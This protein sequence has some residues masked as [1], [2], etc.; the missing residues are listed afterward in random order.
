MWLFCPALALLSAVGYLT[1]QT[2]VGVDLD[3]DD[4][5]LK[6]AGLRIS[7][8]KAS[9]ELLEVNYDELLTKS[10]S[11]RA[12]RALVEQARTYGHQANYR[13]SYDRLWK[14][15]TLADKIGAPIAKADVYV[16]LGRYYSFYKRMDMAVSYFDKALRIGKQ[17]VAIRNA[18]ASV[19]AKY[20]YAFA[21]TYREMDEPAH[22]RRYLDSSVMYT[23]AGGGRDYTHYQK[24]EAG[25]C[26]AQEGK[27][28]EA[29][30]AYRSALPW[31]SDN[32]PGYQTLVYFYL[33]NVYT[34][35]GDT[36]RGQA[37][38]RKALEIS[39]ATSSHL[40]FTPLIYNKLALLYER[41]G[42]YEEAYEMSRRRNELNYRFFDSR[43]RY[44]RP[45]LEIQDD[46]REEQ[47]AREQSEQRERLMRLEEGKRLDRLKLGA[48]LVSLF[49]TLIAAF[50][51]FKYLRTRHKMEKG[52]I[53][54]ERELE[55]RKANEI[56]RL[57]NKELAAS[58]L[59]LIA[60]DE[61]IS[62][63]RDRLEKKKNDVDALE[64]NAIVRSIKA[65]VDNNRNWE[66]FEARFVSVNKDF[67]TGLKERFP[68]LT[69]GDLKLCALIKLNFSS[70]DV[71]R[72]MGISVESVHTTRYRLRKK[73]G[74]VNK[75]NLVEFIAGL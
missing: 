10:D 44:N 67:Y 22:A 13:M 30:A 29:I 35:K 7:D 37:E 5:I 41:M 66:E 28:D 1:G 61:F 72:L 23:V 8:P 48:V 27:Y 73:L 63:I 15:L 9:L 18:P 69:Q 26:L 52:L 40:D 39:E 60:K 59:K 32:D 19:L 54:Q 50:F 25:Y 6:A 24:F 3:Q 49:L 55:V 2:A 53:R 57:K 47:R 31:L 68:K 4:P 43:S 42:R 36:A 45:L 58:T 51:L 62:D 14:A 70:K 11:L 34:D 71:A 12:V 75:E 74:L 46:F 65:S 38:Y 33:G 20:Y 16:E 64:V 17:S 21:A 56:V